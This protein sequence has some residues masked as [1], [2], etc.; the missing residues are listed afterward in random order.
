MLDLAARLA[1]RAAGY[2]E[3]NPLVGCVI[4]R[5]GAVIGVGHHR[6]F[7]GPH[8]EREAI[9]DCRRRG[10]DP[11]G[12]TVYVTLEPCASRGKQP[13]CTE[14]LVEAGVA[15]VVY[16]SEDPNPAKSGGAAFL[17]GRGI[18]CDFCVESEMASGL[19]APFIKRITTGLP[20]VI[21][22]WAQT[23][24]GRIA[25][26]T[27]ESKWISNDRSRARVHRLRARVDG[28]L[29][30]IGT[31]AADD[32]MLNARGVRRVRRN[33][34]R[35]VADS[36]LEI[37]LDAKVVTTA[38]EQPTTIF[39]HEELLTAAI[40]AEKVAALRS[41]GVELIGL[42]P[43]PV[44]SR[45]I[46]LAA[47]LRELVRRH[48]IANVMTE[49]GPAILGSLFEADLIDEAV[50]YL[51][52]MLLGDEL[53]RAAAVGR[54]AESLHA[55]RRL[56]LWRVKRLGDDLEISYRRRGSVPGGT[57]AIAAAPK[58]Q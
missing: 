26:R 14:A 57:A 21:A 15:R 56:N 39:C 42:A 16:A 34:R 9:A 54:V 52:P 48:Q 5:D 44:G 25:T 33:A 3:P 38:Q 36:D 55:A 47:G 46:D 6:K 31:I 53:A 29:S 24:D 58:T 19:A 8:A 4:V 2:V 51:A 37:R 50:V 30:G 43:S 28:I 40:C 22:K 17:R 41:A 49:A 7:G 20:W 13:P 11:R 32:P 12:S 45:G 18:A 35:I 27:G 10:G 23:I 1:W